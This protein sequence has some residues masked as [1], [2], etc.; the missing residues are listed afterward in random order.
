MTLSDR[1]E[2][3]PDADSSGKS[4]FSNFFDEKSTLTGRRLIDNWKHS[5][6]F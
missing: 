4:D 1:F 2:Y 5:H 3:N 6:G